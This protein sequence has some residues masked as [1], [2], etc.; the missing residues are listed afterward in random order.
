MCSNAG[1]S[2]KRNNVDC[3]KLELGNYLQKS[4]VHSVVEATAESV[5]E[6]CL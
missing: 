2:I 1:V 6:F 3:D 5:Y 4:E